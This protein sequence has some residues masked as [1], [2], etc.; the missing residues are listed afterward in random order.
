MTLFLLEET[1]DNFCPTSLPGSLSVQR[2]RPLGVGRRETLATRLQFAIPGSQSR[3]RIWLKN[4]S[5][6]SLSTRVFET[7]TATGRE[8]FA[9]QDRIVS[10]IFLLLISNGGK[11]ISNVDVVVRGQVKSENSSLSVAVRVSKT[12]VLKLPFK[13]PGKRGHIVT[14]TLLPTQMFP[15]LPARATNLRTQILCPGHEKCF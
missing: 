4:I 9:C 7:R 2:A 10:Q 12:R 8:H 13:G 15:R 14:D 3:R 6:G 5:V 1:A 11:I